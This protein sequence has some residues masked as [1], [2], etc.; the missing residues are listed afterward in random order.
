MSK[1]GEAFRVQGK[2]MPL[3][4]ALLR[5]LVPV[6]GAVPSEWGMYH[7]LLLHAGHRCQSCDLNSGG[8]GGRRGVGPSLRR[9][10]KVSIQDTAHKR[11]CVQNGNKPRQFY[12]TDRLE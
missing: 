10:E 3:Q 7:Y 4:A 5:E 6:P 2:R 11:C 8:G 1:S 9:A 12:R